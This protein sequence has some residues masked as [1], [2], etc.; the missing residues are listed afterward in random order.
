MNQDR[1]LQSKTGLHFG[2]PVHP[3]LLGSESWGFGQGKCFFVK[4]VADKLTPFGPSNQQSGELLSGPRHHLFFPWI[5]PTEAIPQ[6]PP[7][8]HFF[9]WWQGTA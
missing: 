5:R 9:P 7:I 4:D 8:G 1:A 3:T 2:K 6:H